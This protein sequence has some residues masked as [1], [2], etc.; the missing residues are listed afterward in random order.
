MTSQPSLSHT[1]GGCGLGHVGSFDQ[2]LSDAEFSP[3]TIR[4]SGGETVT[5]DSRRCGR[6][7]CDFEF[8]DQSRHADLKCDRKG[9]QK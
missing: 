6:V 3:G 7:E 9:V 5:D 2:I 4:R 1:E 8:L